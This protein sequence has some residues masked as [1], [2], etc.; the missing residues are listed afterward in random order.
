MP[1]PRIACCSSVAAAADFFAPLGPT[2]IL[3]STAINRGS[4]SE[5]DILVVRST[6]RITRELL[7]GTPVRFVGT[8]TAGTDHMDT[9]W[10]D[11]AGIRW[12]SAPGCNARSVAEYVMAAL[13]VL[14]RRHG[15]P[16]EG[17][18]LGIIGAGHVGNQV[19]QLAPALGLSLL[20]CDPPLAEA[21]ATRGEPH[22]YVPLSF[23]LHEA[24][25]ITLH[26][27]LIDDGCFRTRRMVDDAFLKAMKPGAVLLNAARGPVVDPD[28]LRR[29]YEAH[30][31]PAHLVLDTWDP[32]PAFPLD[33]LNMTD[34]ATPHIAGY[35]LDG[36][37]AGT[38][39]VFTELLHFLGLADPIPLIQLAEGCTTVTPTC[40][41]MD[42]LAA[43]ADIVPRLH[44]IEETD[45]LMRNMSAQHSPDEKVQ[46]AH[47][48]ELRR[49]YPER[50]EFHTTTLIPPP[51]RVGLSH[52]LER[53]GFRIIVG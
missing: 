18:T 7:D 23:L 34:L 43:L 41:E 25:I 28:A 49:C 51:N 24:N 47:F 11:R 46:A 21:A 9:A 15:L 16:L 19:A 36:R 10:L 30:T 5:T 38:R 14:Q 22:P 6:T 52:R 32:E 48:R 20:L 44:G 50:R 27:P 13:L 12:C 31:A 53:L 29:A 17:R 37:M 35:S 42:D 40:D 8:A 2:R 39:R 26:V 4:L 3:P 1:S 33:I 45:R